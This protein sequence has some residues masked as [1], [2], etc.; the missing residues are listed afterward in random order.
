MTEML[1][2]KLCMQLLKQKQ[3]TFFFLT[4]PPTVV[5]FVLAQMWCVNTVSNPARVRRRRGDVRPTKT[6]Q[7]AVA[8]DLHDDVLRGKNCTINFWE[9]NAAIQSNSIA[10]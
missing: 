9:F 3:S 8:G 5:S 6:P 10:R 2:Q 1:R 7:F 4:N